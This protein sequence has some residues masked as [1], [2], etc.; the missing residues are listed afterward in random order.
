MGIGM[1]RSSSWGIG[2]DQYPENYRNETADTVNPNPK[3]F[4]ITNII[5][6]NDYL[7]AI[8]KYPNCTNYEG[9]KVILFENITKAELLAMNTLDPHFF[10]ENKIIARFKPSTEGIKLA[11]KTM[12][13]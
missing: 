7:F 4:E 6:A 2:N 8:V 11:Y 13:I 9:K 5:E 1:M 3:K 12:G 10:P